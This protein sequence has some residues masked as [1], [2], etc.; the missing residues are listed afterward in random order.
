MSWTEIIRIQTAGGQAEEGCRNYLNALKQESRQNPGNEMIVYT[1]AVVS[2]QHM[3]RLNWRTSHP[4]T[5]ASG[6]SEEL[7]YELKQ[8]GLV[9]HSIWI[10]S[11]E[12]AESTETLS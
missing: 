2:R 4:Q 8:F 11:D 7:I 1:H 6:L 3:I 12:D 9:D 5:P 10:T